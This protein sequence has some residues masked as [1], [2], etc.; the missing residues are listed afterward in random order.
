[1]AVVRLLVCL[2]HVYENFTT[3]VFLLISLL[4]YPLKY[5]FEGVILEMLSLKGLL[6]YF[7]SEL[8]QK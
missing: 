7:I 1:M 3:L 8:S 4:Y 2:Y 6:K 5:N